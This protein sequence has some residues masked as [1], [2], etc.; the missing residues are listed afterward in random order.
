MPSYAFTAAETA[1]LTSY[2]GRGPRTMPAI[3]EFMQFRCGMAPHRASI[4]LD[5]LKVAGSVRGFKERVRKPGHW[6]R[7]EHTWTFALTPRF[8]LRAVSGGSRIPIREG[9]TA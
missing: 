2:L 6:Y 1:A 3:L 4:L 7:Y 9:G 5:R 8:A